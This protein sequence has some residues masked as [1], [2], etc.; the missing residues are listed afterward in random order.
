MAII[1]IDGQ[2]QEVP[3]GSPIMNA[4]DDLGVPFAC[5]AGICA[6]CIITVTE[7]MENLM[8]KTQAEE[9][10]GL[11]SDQRLACQAVIRSGKVI[12]TY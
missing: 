3:D 10:M 5:R 12:A 4:C 9:D 1:V 7:G 8:P 11:A 6:T 2:E